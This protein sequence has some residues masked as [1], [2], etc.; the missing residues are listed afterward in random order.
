MDYPP[1]LQITAP[2][3]FT[4]ALGEFLRTMRQKES[5]TQSELSS[6]A[7]VPVSTLSRFERTGLGSTDTLARLLFALNALDA[8]Q[9]FLKE[10]KRLARL[11]KSLEDYEP[12]SKPRLRIRRKGEAK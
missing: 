9:E 5:W 1:T 12:E 10:R 7:G 3:D 2:R 4:K 6:R 11:P 8:F